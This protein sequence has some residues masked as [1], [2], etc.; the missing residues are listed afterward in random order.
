M[1]RNSAV[2]TWV[3]GL[4]IFSVLLCGC[5]LGPK[6]INVGHLKYNEAIHRTFR[7]ELLLNLVRMKYRELPEFV[8][9]GGIA[10]QYSF[11]SS[12]GMDA[13]FLGQFFGF[14]PNQAGVKGNL[15]RTE[16]P[17]ITYAPLR[18]QEFE[19]RILSPINIATIALMSNKGWAIDRLFRMTVSSLNYVDNA[20]AAGGPTPVCKPDYERF[21]HVS[22]VIRRLQ[23]QRAI[24]LAVADRKEIKPVPVAASTIDGEFF[25][26]A[27]SKGYD[28]KTQGEQVTLE[29]TQSYVALVVHPHAVG[30]A[31]VVEMGRQLNLEPGRTVFEVDMGAK[32]QILKT[33]DPELF[34]AANAD[35]DEGLPPALPPDPGIY[36]P[37]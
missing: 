34:P 36:A 22:Q 20:T 29:R 17:T 21:L 11:E 37:G 9:V 30:S 10:A 23:Q 35:D 25:M 3:I 15:A 26:N 5:A 19:K 1:K 12:F 7:E 31:E 13:N 16:R 24:E 18:G 8:D 32:G 28:V 6:Q 33:Y 4:G 2:F 14:N 27:L